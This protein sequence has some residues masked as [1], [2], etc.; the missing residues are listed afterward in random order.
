MGAT[1]A[2]NLVA[3]VLKKKYFQ[4]KW[5]KNDICLWG[6]SKQSALF[7]KICPKKCTHIPNVYIS[8]WFKVRISSSKKNCPLKMMNNV[9]YFILKA[10]FV[11]KI[12]KVFNMTF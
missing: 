9:F 3:S 6:A 5:I 12:F 11:L 10:P 1:I 4:Q 7:Q 2:V 8:L